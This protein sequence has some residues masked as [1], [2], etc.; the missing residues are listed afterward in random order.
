MFNFTYRPDQGI[1]QVDVVGSWTVDEA[2]RYGAEAGPQFARARA[3]AGRLRLLLNLLHNEILGQDI[4]VPLT[5]AGMRHARGDD[6]MALVVSSMLMKLQMRRM[7]SESG[8]P[9]FSTIAE[10]DAWLALDEGLRQA[11]AR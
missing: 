9:I 10:A 4:I 3:H 2:R 11:T 8:A 5:S 7:F 6:R 1:M